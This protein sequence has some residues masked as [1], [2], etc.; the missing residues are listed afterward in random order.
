MKNI[1]TIDLALGELGDWLRFSGSCWIL[2]T[3]KSSRDIFA[4]LSKILNKD[5]SEIIAKIDPT[6]VN[7]WAPKWIDEWINS[8]RSQ[9]L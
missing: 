7:G 2:L 8:R 4:S 5:D 3:D 9:V 1:Q 6:T